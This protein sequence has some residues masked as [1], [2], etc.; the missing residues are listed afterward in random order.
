MKVS[1]FAVARPAYY[2]RNASSIMPN[3]SGVIS[4]TG[5]TTRYTYTVA[6]GKKALLEVSTAFIS[7]VT[8]ASSSG[9]FFSD[10]RITLAN[11][12]YLILH[13]PHQTDNTLLAPY[14]ASSA[15]AVTLYAGETISSQTTDNSTGGTILFILA[16]KGTL[17]D[18]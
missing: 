17:F 13:T 5:A 16:S 15:A 14:F 8:A 12:D 11:S 1:S 3:Y 4:P 6:A 10:T 2:D 7:R 9:Q 18:A